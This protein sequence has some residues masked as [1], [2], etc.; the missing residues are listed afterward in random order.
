MDP[1]ERDALARA[2]AA[3]AALRGTLADVNGTL[4]EALDGGRAAEEARRVARAWQAAQ[5]RL[6]HSTGQTAVGPPPF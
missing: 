3:L 2:V 5:E 1:A 4:A 6:L